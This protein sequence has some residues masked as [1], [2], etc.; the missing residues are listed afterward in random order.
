MEEQAEGMSEIFGTDAQLK[1]LYDSLEHEDKVQKEDYERLKTEIN[2]INLY[3]DTFGIPRKKGG[4]HLSVLERLS[5]HM[6]KA[7]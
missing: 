3:L 4:K 6:N 1:E 5:I 2:Q 7:A